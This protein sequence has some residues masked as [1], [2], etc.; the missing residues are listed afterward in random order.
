MVAAMASLEEQRSVEASTAVPMASRVT[1]ATQALRAAGS[2]A[3]D[4]LVASMAA[5]VEA[6]STAVEAVLPT[7][8]AVLTVA[9]DVANTCT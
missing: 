6:D 7:V 3:E 2:T 5:V 1:L 4:R 8:V 9:A